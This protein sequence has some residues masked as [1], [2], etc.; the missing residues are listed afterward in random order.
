MSLP[1][2]EL[3]GLTSK[4]AVIY[5]LLLKL[6]ESPAS[7]IIKETGYK[8]ATVYKSLY[9]LEEKLLV[10]QEKSG[11]KIHFK[12]AS[13]TQLTAL[14]DTQFKSL[15]RARND[16]QS[17]LPTLTSNYILSV[18]RPV[19][20]MFEG[21]EGIKTVFKD[22]YAPKSEP[23]YGCVDLEKAD[24]ALPGHIIRKLIPLRIKNKVIAK[25][26][27]ANSDQAELVHKKDSVSLRKSILLDKKEYPLPAEIDVYNDKIA[28]LSFT[29][30]KFVGV[31][32]E[33]KDIA[34]SLKSIFKLAFSKRSDSN[35]RP[36]ERV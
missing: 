13:P 16:L 18:E 25:T 29:K 3:F 24:D 27:I 32:I 35:D 9:S 28:L 36:L 23:V 5:E 2:L 19:I 12:P 7:S 10:T 31:I 6:G 14:A 20:S 11:V 17:M 34:T 26:F 8:R 33:N 30:G 1:F 15:E 22:I 21:K 4:E